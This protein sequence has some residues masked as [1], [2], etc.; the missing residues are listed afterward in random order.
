[1]NQIPKKGKEQVEVMDPTKGM[2]K[3]MDDLGV[4]ERKFGTLNT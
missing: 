2:D 3:V 4:K 1:L